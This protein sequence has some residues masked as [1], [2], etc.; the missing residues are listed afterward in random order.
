M[1]YLTLSA[2]SFIFIGLLSPI[3][4]ASSQ[5]NLLASSPTFQLAKNNKQSLNNAVQSVKQRTGGRI[6]SAKTVKKNG[7]R[8]HKI[9]VLLPSGKIKTFKIKAR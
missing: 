9:K 3:G 5:E 4:Q 2:I 7:H 1:K 8:I 6:L